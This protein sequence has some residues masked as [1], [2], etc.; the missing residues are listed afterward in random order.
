MQDARV[1]VKSEQLDRICPRCKG[2]GFVRVFNPMFFPQ[3]K[4]VLCS[5]CHGEGVIKIIE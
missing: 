3:G 2:N 1:E 5:N 4:P